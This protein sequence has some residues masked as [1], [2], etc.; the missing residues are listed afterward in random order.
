MKHLSKQC[1]TAKQA[2]QYLNSINLDGYVD[3]DYLN[4]C[5]FDFDGWVDSSESKGVSI[6]VT[7]DFEVLVVKYT[8]GDI[9]RLES[10]LL[11]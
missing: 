11:Q 7:R 3:A 10:E 5:D 9:N 1:K 6:Q 2:V 4:S 8:K